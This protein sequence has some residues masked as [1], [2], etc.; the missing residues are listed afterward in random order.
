MRTFLKLPSP[1]AVVA[2]VA[3]VVAG[4]GASYAAGKIDTGDLSKNA[5]TSKKIKNGTIKVKDMKGSA[6]AALKGATGPAGAAGPAGPA[7]AAGAQGPAGSARA[8]AVTTNAGV[9]SLIT[10]RT[11]GFSTLS[12]GGVGIWCLTLSDAT[13]NRDTLAPIVS[14]EYGNTVDLNASAHVRAAAASCAAPADV[15]IRT[16][17]SGVADDEVAFSVMV[18]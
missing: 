12:K 15:E 4:S 10:A 11:S 5:V 17:I 2:V 9:G 14:V 8:Y 3:L 6:V 13:I 18:P 16:A 7:G 1:A